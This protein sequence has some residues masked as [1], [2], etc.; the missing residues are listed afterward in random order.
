MKTIKQHSLLLIAALCASFTACGHSDDNPDN[1]VPNQPQS[2]DVADIVGKWVYTEEGGD[3][4]E[5]FIF[6]TDGKCTWYDWYIVHGVEVPDELRE[7]TYEYLPAQKQIKLYGHSV[8]T[9]RVDKLTA[10]DMVVREIEDG[11]E[12]HAHNYVKQ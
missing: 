5:T 1:S 9:L 2:T 6:G 12:H 10:T 11:K 7:Y 8:I 4:G 3:E